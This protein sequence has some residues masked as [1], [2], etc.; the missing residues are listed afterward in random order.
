MEL[1][2]DDKSLRTLCESKAHARRELGSEVAE[3]LKRRL[4]DMRAATSV[5]DLVAGRPRELEGTEYRHI[6]IDLCEDYRILFCANHNV[7]P[8]LESGDVDWSKVSRIKILRIERDH[9]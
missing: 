4:A 1:A 8:V 7:M 2:F 9:G 6:A 5:K 3:V